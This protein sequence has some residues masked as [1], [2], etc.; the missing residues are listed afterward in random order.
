[1]FGVNSESVRTCLVTGQVVFFP[2]I[3]H[4]SMLSRS[5]VMPVETVT[6]SFMISREMGQ[7]KNGGTSTASII[8][9]KNMGTV[10]LAWMR[11][12]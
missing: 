5:Y 2:E 12:S 11:S 8:G 4:F 7:R 3:S 10:V 6:G 9:R 1:M